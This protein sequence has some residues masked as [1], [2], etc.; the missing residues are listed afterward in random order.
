MFRSGGS[1][2]DIDAATSAGRFGL[3]SLRPLPRPSVFVR[4]CSSELIVLV[5]VALTRILLSVRMPACGGAHVAVPVVRLAA[6]HLHL[7]RR[8]VDPELPLESIRHRPEDL[9]AAPRALLSHQDMAATRDDPGR[10]GPDVQ[11]VHA[12]HAFD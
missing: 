7:D 4:S 5:D 1:G 10:H 3:N 11:V 6:L 8:V 12:L 9:L 2:S